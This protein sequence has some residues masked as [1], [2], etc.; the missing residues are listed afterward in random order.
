LKI[1]LADSDTCRALK[2][3]GWIEHLELSVF[4]ESDDGTLSDDNP[5]KKWGPVQLAASERMGKTF[6]VY[7][8]VKRRIVEAGFVDVRE[9]K[10]K[11]PVGPWSSDKKMKDIGNWN[12]FFFL[13]DTEA[14]CIFLLGKVMGV[15]VSL[16]WFF[17]GP[18]ISSV[19]ESALI[20]NSGTSFLFR[21][22]LARLSLH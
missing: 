8:H 22:G 18:H 21:R 2:P 17:C 1:L 16:Y 20:I 19:L 4:F 9:H 15:S 7:E 5:L 6:A 11:L 14:F 3:G 13:R 10:F 12:M